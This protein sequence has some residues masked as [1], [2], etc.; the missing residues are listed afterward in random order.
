MP[1]LQV[2]I[3]LLLDGASAADIV[4][5]EADVFGTKTVSLKH[6]L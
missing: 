3:V 6:I 5:M 4:C 1:A 2:T